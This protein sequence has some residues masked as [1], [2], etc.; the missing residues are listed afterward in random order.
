MQ[1]GNLDMGNIA[2]QDIS[3]QSGLVH[4]HLGLPFP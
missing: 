4:R 3:N 1:R 2:P